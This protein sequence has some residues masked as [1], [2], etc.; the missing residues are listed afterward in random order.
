MSVSTPRDRAHGETLPGPKRKVLVPRA[1][2]YLWR[3]RRG[4]GKKRAVRN[5]GVSPTPPR[6]G[7]ALGICDQL[8]CTSEG[9]DEIAV[10]GTNA[11]DPAPSPA[12]SVGTWDSD[13]C[14]CCCGAG[15]GCAGR[16]P[17]ST[18]RRAAR[19]YKKRH[20]CTTDFAVENARGCR[21]T[22]ARV[23][24][25]HFR[26][27]AFQNCLGHRASTNIQGLTA[28]GGPGP[29]ARGGP[30]RACPRGRIPRR[31]QLRQQLQNCGSEIL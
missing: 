28:P 5:G 29:W 10:E 25:D 30:R 15:C 20:A 1:C 24:V 23:T 18:V 22:W 8:V 6:T 17:F 2:S 12:G 16:K 31:Q 4:T 11:D 3:I 19:P 13:S 9:P 27:L 26:H 14:C 21:G 7:D